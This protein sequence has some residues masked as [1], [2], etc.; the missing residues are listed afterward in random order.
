MG[1]VECNPIYYVYSVKEGN[2]VI[3][4]AE[5]INSIIYYISTHE[6]EELKTYGESNSKNPYA[7]NLYTVIDNKIYTIENIEDLIKVGGC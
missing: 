6:A 3:Y 1:S 4:H 2:Q 5:S 7:F